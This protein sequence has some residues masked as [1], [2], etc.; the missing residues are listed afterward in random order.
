MEGRSSIERPALGDAAGPGTG[1][2]LPPPPPVPWNREPVAAPA[3]LKE[4]VGPRGWRKFFAIAGIVFAFPFLLTIPGW[5]ALSAYRKWKAGERQQPTGLIVWGVIAT[6][7]FSFAFV[8]GLVQDAGPSAGS[9]APPGAATS[10]AVVPPS[11]SAPPGFTGSEVSNGWTAYSSI[12]EG[13]SISLPPGWHAT[14]YGP[15]LKFSAED[16][17]TSYAPVSGGGR[18]QLHVLRLPVSEQ[19]IPKRY[20]QFVRLQFSLDPKT[21]GDVQMTTSA[22]PSGNFYVL[23][24]VLKTKLGQVSVTMYGLLHDTSEYRLVLVAPLRH[25]DEYYDEFD[26]IVRTFS[27]DS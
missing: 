10:A 21:V 17:D 23:R 4:S 16:R 22:L 20:Y 13:F 26:G 8:S 7:L 1:S 5:I 15:R 12:S 19:E 11:I 2:T 27:P 9:S 6:L 18:P 3:Q 25:A 24:N 14:N